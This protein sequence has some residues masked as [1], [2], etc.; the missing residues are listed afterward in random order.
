MCLNL[1]HKYLFKIRN[2]N[3]SCT[4]ST[5]AALF[6]TSKQGNDEKKCVNTLMSDPKSKL[7]IVNSK[8]L[9][10]DTHG[11]KVLVCVDFT[12]KPLSEYKNCHFTYT[13]AGAVSF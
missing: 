8:D 1:I 7:S 10:K 5:D 6:F 4:K 13:V 11:D 3:S 9:D 2:F 12:T